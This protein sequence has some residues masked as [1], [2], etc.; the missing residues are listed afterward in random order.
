[1]QRLGLHVSAAEFGGCWPTSAIPFYEVRL[2]ANDG[3]GAGEVG[4]AGRAQRATGSS[5][6][7]AKF[8]STDMG[9]N[10]QAVSNTNHHSI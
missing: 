3:A 10:K 9:D 1:M 8:R 6:T 2:G 7:I 5:T 4:G